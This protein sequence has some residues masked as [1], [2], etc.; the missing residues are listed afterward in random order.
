MLERLGLLEVWD[1]TNIPPGSRWNEE[2]ERQ[3]GRATAAI[4]LISADLLASPVIDS[5]VARV[6]FE[7]GRRG[8]R[9][10]PVLVRACLWRQVPW[11][12]ML[13]MLPRDGRALQ[14]LAPAEIETCFV[15]VAETVIEH[16]LTAL[17]HQQRV[18]P[19]LDESLPY[20]QRHR[21]VISKARF[22]RTSTRAVGRDEAFRRLQSA[23]FSRQKRIVVVKG[24]AAV[25]KTTF[26]NYWLEWLAISGFVDTERAFAFSFYGH[27]SSD[28][29]LAEA[30]DWFA[31]VEREVR[32][33]TSPW[34]RA[35]MLAHALR[36]K[37]TLLVL[38]GIEGLL[39][40]E[41]GIA[42]P[43]ADPGLAVLLAGV[44]A[45][46]GAVNPPGMV[47]LTT[48]TLLA[49]ISARDRDIEQIDLDALT[50]PA[51]AELLRAAGL[52]GDLRVLEQVSE[53][54][55]NDA[56]ALQLLAGYLKHFEHGSLHGCATIPPLVS[57]RTGHHV[58]RLFRAFVQRVDS[59][60]LDLL[61]VVGLCTGDIDLAAVRAVAA[62]PAI[63]G[64]TEHLAELDADA[65][66]QTV[67]HLRD[68]ALLAPHTGGHNGVIDAHPLVR[69]FFGTHLRKCSPEAWLAGQRRLMA[70]FAASTDT[71]PTSLERMTPLFLAMRHGCLAREYDHVWQDIYLSRV[72]RGRDFYATDVLGAI[73]GE[74]EALRGFLRRRALNHP[75]T[76]VVQSVGSQTRAF[77]M[78]TLG[79]RLQALGRA[80]PACRLF[81]KALALNDNNA[82][83]WANLSKA[84]LL[85]GEVDAALRAAER[86]VAAADRASP[87]WRVDTRVR[88]A[89]A[90]HAAG[91]RDE[92][93]KTF[94]EAAR[95]QVE[96]YQ[97]ACWTGVAAFRYAQ[98]LTEL[99]R[100]DDA[101]AAAQQ[102]LD[103]A[104][105][106][107]NDNH[108][109]RPFERAMSTLAWVWVAAGHDR[110]QPQVHAR[111]SRALD[112]LRRASR[113]DELPHAWLTKA[114]VCRRNNDLDGACAAVKAVMDVVR[115]AGMRLFEADGLLE[116]AR[117]A[118]QREDALLARA[119]Y[120]RAQVLIDSKQYERRR[121]ELEQLARALGLTPR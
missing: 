9:F 38:D 98:L 47:V 90:Q 79:Y 24:W 16:V 93:L 67:A 71:H 54:F 17:V 52:P 88:L 50:A 119:E 114:M 109:S 89:V 18:A 22:R 39:E 60:A 3:V 101:L 78:G 110:R 75:D 70:H 72:Q 117:I 65:L 25:G 94:E 10:V 120:D 86:G 106:A 43:I 95:H 116:A 108:D 7:C 46:S 27:G 29:F 35:E 74:V 8:L 81:T 91:R 55:G 62:A 21:E 100:I 115:P 36:A 5:Q 53:E 87:D 83:D 33:Q 37:R 64:L 45:S 112:G 96:L 84:E 76:D 121:S 113:Q 63:P 51:G 41:H 103:E 44:R 82:A 102:A 59:A 28:L 4:C 11:L 30:L 26:V 68:L 13:Q 80:A 97:R 19:G 1:V 42:S 107:A 104:E 49:G 61:H 2:L 111:L 99:G 23:W 105:R 34:V 32:E 15:E 40:R 66:L 92:A 118:L 48:R 56:F 73:A 12:T 20:L 14:A 57:R 58:R 69:R 31:G 6:L 85:R 77:I